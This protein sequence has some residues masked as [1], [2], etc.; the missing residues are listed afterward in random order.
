MTTRELAFY[1]DLGARIRAAREAAGMTQL[2]LAMELGR[3]AS[4]SIHHYEHAKRRIDPYTLRR[5][6][7]VLG[8]ELYR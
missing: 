3:D 2:A 1:R 7:R 4:V 5:L 6:E 8:Q